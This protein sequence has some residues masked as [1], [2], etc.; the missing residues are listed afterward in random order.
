LVVKKVTCLPQL[1]IIHPGNERGG[2]EFARVTS[3]LV[4]YS[5]RGSGNGTG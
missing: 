5:A 1:V 3:Q 2:G 4:E